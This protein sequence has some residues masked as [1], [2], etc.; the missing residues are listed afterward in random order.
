MRSVNKVALGMRLRLQVTVNSLEMCI[1]RLVLRAHLHPC[2]CSVMFCIGLC[3]GPVNSVAISLLISSPLDLSVA[4]ASLSLLYNCARRPL[5]RR[6]LTQVLHPPLLWKTSL[7]IVAPSTVPRGFRHLLEQSS[8][9][10]SQLPNTVPSC[11]VSSRVSGGAPSTE[12]KKKAKQSV[13]A[14][15][16]QPRHRVV[17][18]SLETF[19]FGN[20]LLASPFRSAS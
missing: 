5:L 14:I 10:S 1:T 9:G 3:R 16:V 8:S 20:M 17:L 18:R 11:G 15:S 13:V 6:L 19:Y 12:P 7:G 4:D 2:C